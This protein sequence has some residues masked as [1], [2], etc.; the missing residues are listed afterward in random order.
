VAFHAEKKGGTTKTAPK[1]KLSGA[2]KMKLVTNL[3]KA[4]AAKA[5]KGDKGGEGRLGYRVE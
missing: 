1:W 3:A 5:A 2:G 4:R